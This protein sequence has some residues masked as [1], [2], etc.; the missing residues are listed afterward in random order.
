MSN[1]NIEYN[2]QR[3][4]LGSM[5]RTLTH[6]PHTSCMRQSTMILCDP[7]QNIEVRLDGSIRAA[8][9]RRITLSPQPPPAMSTQRTEQSLDPTPTNKGNPRPSE[10]TDETKI[11]IPAPYLTLYTSRRCDHRGLSK[12]CT[13]PSGGWSK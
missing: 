9:Y 2:H 13:K 7:V 8:K 6:T 1:F 4:N 5:Y 10:N 3:D 11:A 12:G